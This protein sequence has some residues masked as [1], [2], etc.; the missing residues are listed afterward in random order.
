MS[1]VELDSQP[2]HGKRIFLVVEDDVLYC[3]IKNSLQ[4]AG[5]AVFGA[6]AHFP[7]MPI[8]IPIIRFDAALLDVDGDSPSL[9][10]IVDDLRDREIPILMLSA[11]DLASVAPHLCEYQQLRKPYAESDAIDR[12]LTL[13]SAQPS[14]PATWERATHSA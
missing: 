3:R 2:L 6:L 8:E 1:E 13:C 9:P 10:D 7:D 5:G 11:Y 4:A 12:L 14:R